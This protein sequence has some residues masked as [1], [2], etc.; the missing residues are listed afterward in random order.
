MSKVT[1]LFLLIAICAGLTGSVALAG[2]CVE[3]FQSTS[4]PS[5]NWLGLHTDG[6]NYGAGQ[7]FTLNCDSRLESVALKI[8]WGN[9][10]GEVRSFAYGDTI[11]LSIMTPEG[12]E[13]ARKSYMI[14]TGLA[15]RTV[16]FQMTPDDVL[17]AAGTYVAACWTDVAACGGLGAYNSDV[18]DGTPLPLNDGE[19]SDDLVDHHR[20]T[21]AH[22]L[23]EQR[24]SHRS[25]S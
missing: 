18:V 21:G 17:L 19:R 24:V 20:G 16:T 3:F 13:L 23:R 1:T 6:L 10:Y 25:W 22:D 12:I 14:D 8:Y 11:H 9:D 7:S 15:N 5:G 4:S 2:D